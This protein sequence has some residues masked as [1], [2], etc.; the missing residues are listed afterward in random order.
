MK[1]SSAL[2]GPPSMQDDELHGV[3]AKRLPWL[4]RYR[5]YAL[6]AV[7][8]IPG[9]VWW[10]GFFPATMTVDSLAIWG[11]VLDGQA[12][13]EMPVAYWVFVYLTS[14]GGRALALVELVQTIGLSFAV[15][16]LGRAMG[17]SLL[18]S[19]VVSG[20]VM[21]SPLAGQFAVTLWKDVPFTVLLIGA[22]A[23]WA[24]SFRDH[25]ARKFRWLGFVLAFLAGLMRFEAPAVLAVSGCFVVALAFL[26]ETRNRIRLVR[27][28]LGIGAVAL[29]ALLVASLAQS[30][31]VGR[32]LPT[33][34]KWIPAVADLAYVA[35]ND[36]GADRAGVR[37]ARTWISGNAVTFAEDCNANYRLFYDDGFARSAV[38]NVESQIPRWWLE[39]LIS[40]PFTIIEAHVCRGAPFLPP[41]LSAGPVPSNW[42]T[43]TIEQNDLGLSFG[44][45]LALRQ[46]LVMW[47]ALWTTR[48]EVLAWPGLWGLIGSVGLIAIGRWKRT[49]APRLQ[50][51]AVIWGSLLPIA[52][53]TVT[54]D[55]RYAAF[56]QVTGAAV[57]VTYLGLLAFPV[58]NFQSRSRPRSAT[59]TNSL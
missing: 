28:G 30:L 15:F 2:A 19:A 33:W 11:A 42:V 24:T 45:P 20:L 4:G 44:S 12:L 41:P 6:F 23:L 37:E 7:M 36:P 48:S 21:A 8:L 26:A 50:I 38:R 53:W 13:A 31:F 57:L 40:N 22:T 58:Q 43:T 25:S 14:L 35:V 16:A 1:D 47:T 56:A 46:P 32:G 54:F 52:A 27:T 18:R 5:R 29:A 55:F 39:E 59:T 34:N 51:A 9:I 10:L 3:S 17:Q 49:R